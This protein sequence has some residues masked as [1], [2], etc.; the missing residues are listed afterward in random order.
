MM[1]PKGKGRPKKIAKGFGK[2]KL[3]FSSLETDNSIKLVSK[4]YLN[5]IPGV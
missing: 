2:R 3:D 1:T 4:D 5:K